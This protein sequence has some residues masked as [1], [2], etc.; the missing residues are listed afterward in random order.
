MR[1]LS[2][3]GAALLSLALVAACSKDDGA[4]G[5]VPGGLAVDSTRPIDGAT[6]MPFVGRQLVYFDRA[7]DGL[8]VNS[9]TI[10]VLFPNSSPIPGTIVYDETAHSAVMNL[11]LVP[12]VSYTGVVTVNV[13]GMDGESLDSTYRWSFQTRA[14]TRGL[15]DPTP[16]TGSMPQVGT[17]AAGVVHVAYADATTGNL[18]YA[19]CAA[20]CVT[21]S[22]WSTVVVANGVGSESRL[23]LSVSPAGRVAISYYLTGPGALGVSV[24]DGACG[25]V[26]SWQSVMLED[27][28]GD[29]GFGASVARGPDDAL[30]VLFQ[31]RD[32]ETVRYTTCVATCGNTAG[33]S[34]SALIDASGIVGRVSSLAVAAT[35]QIHAAWTDDSGSLVVYGGC[36]SNC[37]DPGAWSIASLIASASATDRLQLVVDETN[38]PA[39]AFGIDNFVAIGLCVSTAC[40][41]DLSWA[42]LLLTSDAVPEAAISLAVT[43]DRIH[44][45]YA[46]TSTEIRYLT[47][48]SLCAASQ[49]QW[50]GGSFDASTGASDGAIAALPD[51]EPVMV[52]RRAAEGLA[53][54]R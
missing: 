16:G 11:A 13:R 9:S 1:I 36:V 10:G 14:P 27:Q 41:S 49:A 35:G 43:E 22:N 25:I 24:C 40:A 44:L 19:Q 6:A 31:D 32:A 23:G 30:H 20:G 18:K 17:D 38:R 26:G 51:G 53:F 37:T 34:A 12:G 39:V 50:V 33:W 54:L 21:P 28:S 15:I 4:T 8:T 29:V 3:A 42:M 46:R 7:L 2:R 52:V 47:C 45:A 48:T 5:P